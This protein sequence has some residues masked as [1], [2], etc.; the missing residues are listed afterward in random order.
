MKKIILHFISLCLFITSAY[1]Q[2][3]GIGTTIPDSTL[4]IVG[5][6]KYQNGSQ[7][8]GKVLTSDAN[9]GATWAAAS[10]ISGT[11]TLNYLPKWTPNGTTLGNSSIKD[12]GTGVSIG[13]VLDSS[14]IT[15][16]ANGAFLNAYM[17]GGSSATASGVSSFIL[18]NGV[19]NVTTATPSVL[20]ATNAGAGFVG[21]SSGSTATASG[22]GSLIL[23]TLS[24]NTLQVAN[25]S[26]SGIWAYTTGT[27]NN[28]SKIYSSGLGSHVIG[29]AQNGGYIEASG[30][31]SFIAALASRTSTDTTRIKATANGTFILGGAENGGQMINNNNGGG[32]MGFLENNSKMK[33]TF[34]HGAMVFGHSYGSKGL[35][36]TGG[37]GSFVFGNVINDSAY[38]TA[39]G[40]FLVGHSISN[41][42]TNS[43][44]FGR[45]I[46][47]TANDVI[48][49]GFGGTALTING[50]TNNVGIGTSTP[51]SRLHV[52]DA[53]ASGTNLV[54]ATIQSA[55]A[56]SNGSTITRVINDGYSSDIEQNSGGGG[57]RFGTY[58]DMN[59]VNNYVS[60]GGAFGNINLVTGNAGGSAIV[61]TIG[62]GTQKGKVGIG[63]ITPSELLDVNGTIKTISFQMTAGAGLNKILQSDAGGVASWVNSA[64]PAHTIGESYGGG[65]VF[66]VYDNGQHGLIAA[67]ADQSTGIQWYN[68]ISKYTGTTGDGLN[69]GAMNTVL[70]VVTQ[71][72]DNQ[73]GNFAAKVCSDYSITMSNIIYGDWYLPSKYELNL[74]YL[75]KTV[76]GGFGISNY[77]S[78]S[79]VN[80]N[81]FWSQNLDIGNQIGDLKSNTDAV[82]AVRA[83]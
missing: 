45:G 54:L 14:T 27:G 82:R 75:Q 16:S 29:M 36:Q 19:I 56:N 71:M 1:A 5:G 48:K 55:S 18:G 46:Y 81:L 60:S 30:M 66:Y 44:I 76:V 62:G 67:I 57:F 7:G 49:M 10:G 8:S 3:I 2:N 51:T 33:N 38:N 13:G 34:G 26:G 52:Y 39:S 32:I 53:A 74:L 65:I 23:G 59:I 35:L 41:T 72:A 73:T 58:T 77:C 68:G 31:G 70:I 22:L 63:T 24:R 15:T 20:S 69:A 9:G 12:N 61:M 80:N 43:T 11:G 78:S 50:A 4:H 21:F 42:G 40:A 37:D 47:N 79:E 64:T 25:N 6:L 83:F 17:T 28:G